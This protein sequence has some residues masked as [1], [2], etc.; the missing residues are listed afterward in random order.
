M[1]ALT[2]VCCTSSEL[3]LVL[4]YCLLRIR[5]Q[6]QLNLGQPGL[7]KAKPKSVFTL[8]STKLLLNFQ[9]LKM[10]TWF[11]FITF[12]SVSYGPRNQ[13]GL[14]G[15]CRL[16][17]CGQ[18]P[19]I[20]YFW[21]INNYVCDLMSYR[22]QICCAGACLPREAYIPNLKKLRKPF[23]RYVQVSK[24]LC[25]FIFFFIF[26]PLKNCSNL[27]TCTWNLMHLQGIWGN[28]WYLEL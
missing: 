22:C 21:H 7:G 18:E 1:Y 10:R 28:Y 27:Q 6:N 19:T 5:A 25:F 8:R 16:R 3:W 9:Y 12:P 4:L 11:L 20:C 2:G 24:V 15:G 23:L 13:K 26:C 14:K 17:I